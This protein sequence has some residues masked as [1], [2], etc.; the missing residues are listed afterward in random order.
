MNDINPL[1][2]GGCCTPP[3]FFCTLLKKSS[4][5]P[6]LKIIDYSQLFIA[7]APMKKTNPKFLIYH[8]K[9]DFCSWSV[10]SPMEERAYKSV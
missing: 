3:V 9:G 5:N 4:G 2:H 6:Y 7:D 8:L 10:K 1:I